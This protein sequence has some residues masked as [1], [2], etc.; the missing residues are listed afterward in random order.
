MECGPQILS[1]VILYMPSIT[2]YTLK[3]ADFQILL[4]CQGFYK[5][6]CWLWHP[7]EQTLWG[8][9]RIPSVIWYS[10]E[11]IATDPKTWNRCLFFCEP[12]HTHLAGGSQ[13]V[14]LL[15][16]FSH[17]WLLK[18]L[19]TIARQAPLSMDS[20]GNNTGVGCHALLQG[21]FL[22]RRLNPDL[23]CLLH[24]KRMFYRWSTGEAQ[25]PRQWSLVCELSELPHVRHQT[26][27]V[28]G[29]E[30]SWDMTFLSRQV[31]AIRVPTVCTP[32]QTGMMWV[33]SKHDWTNALTDGRVSRV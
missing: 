24:Y 25:T 6:N 27:P 16:S 9:N 28:S 17:V 31:R 3:N 1:G 10:V 5:K 13:G 29:T 20:P 15:S 8:W 19:W 7:Q 23:L 14:C 4:Y 11:H 2:L 18:T 21:I 22:T 30:F 32:H 26:S 33:L 12:T